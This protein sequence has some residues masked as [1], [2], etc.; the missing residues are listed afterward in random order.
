MCVCV[1]GGCRVVSVFL[2]VCVLAGEG[3]GGSIWKGFCVLCG[4][5]LCSATRHEFP[6]I[7]TKPLHNRNVGYFGMV[8]GIERIE[9]EA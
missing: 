4:M 7:V 5:E 9:R 3:W 8:F 1:V 6:E 2:S